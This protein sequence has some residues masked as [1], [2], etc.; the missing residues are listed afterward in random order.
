MGGLASIRDSLLISSSEGSE[1]GKAI[2][3]QWEHLVDQCWPREIG[4]DGRREGL[5]PVPVT[6]LIPVEDTLAWGP[7][8]A[9]LAERAKEKREEEKRVKEKRADDKREAELEAELV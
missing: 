7:R 5:D 2:V 6:H 1:E 4:P 8:R 9:Y 3:V